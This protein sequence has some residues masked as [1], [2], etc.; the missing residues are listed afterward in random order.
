MTV[1]EWQ[2]RLRAQ[3]ARK[4]N[5]AISMLPGHWSQSAYSVGS[6]RS[7]RQYTVIYH[8]NDSSYNAC[9]CMDFR[10]NGLGTCKHIE[11]VKQWLDSKNLTPKPLARRTILDLDYRYGRR[12]RMRLCDATPKELSLAAM[13]FFD[14]DFY[15]TIGMVP[16]LP[17]FIEQARRL[18]RSFHCTSD[19]LTYIL[20][21][22]DRLRREQLAAEMTDEEIG[23]VLR[24]ELYPYQI[25][26]IR[27]AFSAGRLLL[28]DEMGLG[29]TVQALGAAELLRS[30]NMVGS[31]L[32]VCPTSLKYQ[33]KKEIER[34]T[35]VEVGIVEGLASVRREL[36]ASAEPYKIVSYHTLANDIKLL[37]NLSTDMLIMDE[38]QRL[39]NWNT[40]ISQAARRVEAE[41][42]VIISGTP[43]ENK[44][45]EL[46]SVM[47]FVDQY[48][49]GP[50]H[51]FLDNTVVK[52]S[53]GKVTGYR[54]LG[55]IAARLS[56]CMV[57]RRKS[58]VA[59]QLPERTDTTL[60]VP[61]TREQKEI[62]DEAHGIVARLVYK[63]R[64]YRFLS[65]K[66]RK[67]LLLML[68]RMRM[69]CGSTYVLD[70]KTHY[71]TKVAET[72]QLLTSMIESGND[73]AVVFSQWERMTQLIAHELEAADIGFEYLNGSVSS[74]RR[75][76]MVENFAVDASKRVFLSTDT[77]STG[78]NLQAAGVIINLDLP[79]NPAVLEQRIARVHRIGQQHQ[80]HVINLVAAGTIEEKMLST[81]KFK[82]DLFSGIM[83]G[84]EDSITLDDNKLT[85]LAE[86][87]TDIIEAPVDELMIEEAEDR[88]V[89]QAADD[90][91][92]APEQHEVLKAG[93]SFLAALS[94]TLQS[95]EATEKLLD[96]I[97]RIDASTGATELHVPVPSREAV[98]NLLKS[99]APLLK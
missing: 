80:I 58:D 4:S 21:E 73:K 79:W 71:D 12:L 3:M 8:G 53:T 34:F 33:W 7:R 63:W 11:A 70:L 98:A 9:G 26:G 13:R 64:R 5:F 22:R 72:V 15:A 20:E 97:V 87:L 14:D 29:K 56:K 1:E 47:Q 28:A 41:Y 52:T 66:D 46:Y 89:A 37:G 81:L 90:D 92:E 50:L 35:G 55:D 18:D 31:V 57:R 65:E 99:L 96:S 42:V 85:R 62:H 19:A 84:G 75:G 30:R 51:H 10:T 6:P 77:G 38:V 91:D 94:Q 23:S 93:M 44:I 24:T 82:A 45:E 17:S 32:I 25:E 49:L 61:M 86:S 69:V 43:L 48:A 78:L 68:S 59:L 27:R 39:K 2:S 95:Q 88:Q 74:A 83:D 16:E 40:Q 67:R 54:K 76:A 60:F 36:Y